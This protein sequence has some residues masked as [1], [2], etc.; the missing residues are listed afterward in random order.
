MSL[1]ASD[2]LTDEEL[3]E[4]TED[5]LSHVTYISESDKKVQKKKTMSKPPMSPKSPYLTSLK[6]NPR[7]SVASAWRATLSQSPMKAD[8]EPSQ[9]RAAM[10]SSTPDYLKEAFGMKKPKHSRSAS[11]GYVPGTPDFKEK[12]DMYDEILELKKT[13]QAQRAESDQMRAKVRRLEE[14]TTRKERQI[15]QLLDPTKGPEHTRSLVDRKAEGK[16]VVQGL[17]QRILRLEQQSREKEA[18]LSKLQSELKTTNMEEMKITM[19]TYYEEVQRLRV[20]LESAEKSNKMDSV[21]SRKQQKVLR[22]TVLK[23]TKEVK[24]L[25]EENAKLKQ[26]AEQEASIATESL[27]NRAKGYIEWSKQRLVRRLL[28]LERRLEER[29]SRHATKHATA[30]KSADESRLITATTGSEVTVTAACETASVSTETHEGLAVGANSKLI[31]GGH[32]RVVSSKQSTP[33]KAQE[34]KQQHEELSGLSAEKDRAL[35]DAETTLRERTAEH[36]RQAENYR[37][38]IQSLSAKITEL[39]NQL[40]LA[41]DS[42]QTQENPSSGGPSSSSSSSVAIGDEEQAR[43]EQAAETIQTHWHAHQI[44]DS[45]LMQSALRAHLSRH[46]Q[47]L[48]L[49]K[50][51]SDSHS[52]NTQSG[53]SQDGQVVPSPSA[54]GDG[55]EEEDVTLLQSVFRG[56]LRRH[57]LTAD[58][59]AR[60]DREPGAPAAVKG[61][62]PSPSPSSSSSS[63]QTAAA[64]AAAWL[65]AA[66][67]LMQHSPPAQHS[68]TPRPEG[69]EDEEI[70]EE[71]TEEDAGEDSNSHNALFKPPEISVE[72]DQSQARDNCDSDDSDDIIVSPSRPMG[73]RMSLFS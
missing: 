9:S 26:E 34:L 51:A 37:E 8:Y 49:R 2:F 7:R 4:L 59:G 61:K 72:F 17:K 36:E 73:R 6:Q 10:S 43:R 18:A 54:R 55:L 53:Q 65:P 66:P 16:S 50:Q 41:Q 64:A 12:E 13:L 5:G 45:V 46:K 21:E 31:T 68:P 11:N 57:T 70:E 29:R 20:L 38:E 58:R 25:Q 33:G 62:P 24:E 27:A 22:A 71:I 67:S 60:V 48:K 19:E 42:S 23:L 40:R 56:H 28:D 3:E 63:S 1:G 30:E 35:Q 14:E 15:E 47:L 32:C 69:S 39:Q 52:N 44:R